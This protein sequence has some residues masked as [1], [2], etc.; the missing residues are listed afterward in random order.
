MIEL[1]WSIEPRLHGNGYAT[2]TATAADRRGRAS[3]NSR[4]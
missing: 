3:S 4:R 1:A 2:E